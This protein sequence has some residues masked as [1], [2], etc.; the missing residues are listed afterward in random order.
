MRREA[1]AEDVQLDS[2]LSLAIRRLA[3]A[4]QP[5]LLVPGLASNARMWDSVAS[6][7][8][9]HGHDVVSVDLRGHGRSTRPDQGYTT[10]QSADD[11]AELVTVLGWTSRPPVVC[12]QSWG[13]NVVLR[14]ATRRGLVRAAVM[15]D[16]GWIHLSPRFPTFDQCWEV[17]APPTP[18]FTSLETARAELAA[19]FES[20]P[21]GAVDAVLA[22]LEVSDGRVQ[23][24]LS[25][26]HHRSILKSLWADDPQLTY[27]AV[28]V[29]CLFLV[30][31]DAAS[32]PDKAAGVQRA[33][34]AIGDCSTIWYPTG[35][36]DLH[37][38]F[39]GR[40]AEDMLGWHRSLPKAR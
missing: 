16:G 38:Q 39:P 30:A 32:E 23:N 4:E 13:G 22:N 12:G 37:L 6:L 29:P 11:L 34:E 26:A 18:S 36:H 25:R 1:M 7:L 24:R 2:G 28:T 17:L 14:L 20:W 21:P 35:H 9:A 31:G 3:G 33:S 27:A 40:V 8:A 10:Q 5:F 15:V 19:R